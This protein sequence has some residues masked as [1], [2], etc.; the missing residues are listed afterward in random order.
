MSKPKI[1]TVEAYLA[2]APAH[3][4]AKLCEMRSVLQDI[5]PNATE[6]IKWGQPVLIEK[7]I[8]FSYAAFK[9]FIR[10]MP[11]GPSLE[12]FRD[13]L[14]SYKTGQD[15]IQF[16]YDQPLPRKLIEKIASHRH[17]DVLENDAKWMY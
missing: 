8:L 14:T 3:A 4:Q 6:A 5:A 1:T 2:A 16:R 17:Q 10:F 13:E 15:T 12:P 11:T 9:D 7:R